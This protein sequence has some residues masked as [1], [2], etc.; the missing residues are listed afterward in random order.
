MIEEDRDSQGRLRVPYFRKLIR[1]YLE[2]HRQYV[3]QEFKDYV[4]RLGVLA[5]ADQYHERNG[6][7]IWKHRVDRARQKVFTDV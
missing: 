1:E 6:Y 3:A 2:T 5:R 4:E 7:T